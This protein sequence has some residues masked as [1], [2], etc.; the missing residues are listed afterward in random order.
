[1]TTENTKVNLAILGTASIL[2]GHLQTNL[3]YETLSSPDTGKIVL[4]VEQEIQDLNMIA[5]DSKRVAI[6]DLVS[7]GEDT[8]VI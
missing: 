8:I 3:S 2:I 6:Q 5:P 1:M 4:P 7:V